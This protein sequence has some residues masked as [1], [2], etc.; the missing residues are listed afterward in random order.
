MAKMNVAGKSAVWVTLENGAQSTDSHE[1]IKMA[2]ARLR[3]KREMISLMHK[4]YQS[5]KT[6]IVDYD[7]QRLE[8]DKPS[9]W[10]G[11]HKVVYIVFRDETLV[12][13][14]ARVNVLSVTDQSIF[15]SFPGNLIRHQ[16]RANYR[17][18]V[19]NE[20]TVT[21]IYKDKMFQGAQISDVSANGILMCTDSYLPFDQGVEIVGITLFFPGAADDLAVGTSIPISKGRVMR[22]ARN[23][24]K[25]YC[26]GI[27]FDLTMNEEELLLQYVRQR[28]RDLLRKGLVE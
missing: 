17:V 2:L 3:K 10:P 13:N 12:W 15:V 19:P 8:I 14:Q 18:D 21:F 25:K 26:Y 22:Y 4:G 5:P 23:D 24:N 7:D 27:L 20:S 9:D 11:T 1:L 16:R 6:I 28:E